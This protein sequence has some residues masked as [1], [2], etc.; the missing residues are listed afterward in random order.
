M[1]TKHRLFD[2]AAKLAGGA[3]GTLAGVRREIEALA[4][5]QLDRLLDGMELVTRDEF[6]AV[7]A[8]AAA[9]RAKRS[10]AASAATA[11]SA[12]RNTSSSRRSSSA[13]ENASASATTH[14]SAIALQ[15][16]EVGKQPPFP[17]AGASLVGDLAFSPGLDSAEVWANQD[18]FDLSRLVGAPPDAFNPAGQRW[19]LPMRSASSRIRLRSSLSSGEP[20]PATRS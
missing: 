17:A 8:M 14:P 12:P 3:I 4:R 5:Q 9:A 2:D 20:M 18:Q 11:A 6:E 13:D 16:H 15:P 1:Q 19:G 10:A 7:K